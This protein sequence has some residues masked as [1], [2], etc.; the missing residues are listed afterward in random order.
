MEAQGYNG[1]KNRATWNISLWIQNDEFLYFAAVAFM[2][3]YQGKRPYKTFIAFMGMERDRTP[4]RFKYIS[5][6]LCYSEL[7]TMM[8]ELV[9]D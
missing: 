1:W 6:S 8:F 5:N 4:D 7:N 3:R 9:E 2:H